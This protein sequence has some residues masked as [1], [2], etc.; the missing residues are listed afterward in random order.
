MSVLRG[1]WES[2]PDS[3]VVTGVQEFKSFSMTFPGTLAKSWNK[4]RE[5]IHFP[6]KEIYISHLKG[7]RNRKTK[8]DQRGHPTRGLLPNDF[9]G[10]TIVMH[11]EP[12]LGTPW[13]WQWLKYM[14]HARL[15]GSELGRKPSHQLLVL[16]SDMGCPCFMW[17]FLQNAKSNTF[18]FTLIFVYLIP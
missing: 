12:L 8:E 13:G 4:N 6:F 18:Y 17:W 15:L 14:S 1:S 2:H 10:Q 3:H 7:R 11:P 16:P 5:P 9:N